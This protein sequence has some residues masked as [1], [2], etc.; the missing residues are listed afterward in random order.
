MFVSTPPFG[1]LGFFYGVL[2]EGIWKLPGCHFDLD[3]S[4][5]IVRGPSVGFTVAK[6]EG[7]GNVFTG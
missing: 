6:D 3:T 4:P 7:R 5:A 2:E 1:L